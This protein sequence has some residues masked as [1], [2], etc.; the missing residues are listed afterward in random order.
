MR[1]SRGG[2]NPSRESDTIYNSLK[3]LFL[4]SHDE[5]HILYVQE[6]RVAG[7]RKPHASA[8]KILIKVE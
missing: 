4:R 1:P 5:Q 6:A 2:G 8:R 3:N 7:H